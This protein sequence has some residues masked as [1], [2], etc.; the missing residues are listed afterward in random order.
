MDEVSELRSDMAGI[1]LIRASLG[2]CPR[3]PASPL[4]FPYGLTWTTTCPAP[5]SPRPRRC[6]QKGNIDLVFLYTW[7]FWVEVSEYPVG[8]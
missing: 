2:M 6:H 1:Y 5:P 8:L 7:A 4:L 3:L